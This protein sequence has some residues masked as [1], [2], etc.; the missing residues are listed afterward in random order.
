[1]V[2]G[3][4]RGGHARGVIRGAPTCYR[5]GMAKVIPSRDEG[6]LLVAAIRVQAHLDGRPP[7]INDVADLLGMPRELMQVLALGLESRG[8]V[9]QLT[10]AFE[11]R[12]D[13]VDAAAVDELPLAG[14]GP[15]LSTELDDFR[16]AFQA[17]QDDLRKTF[18]AEALQ[19]KTDDRMDHLAEQLR[20]F[21]D[22]GSAGPMFSSLSG[23]PPDDDDDD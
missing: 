2:A 10:N 22:K 1:M 9:R 8:I 18:G 7:L 17:K 13:I 3:R 19:K 12:L 21:K 16:K 5:S 14:A 15:R 20:K 6:H 23:S 11:T 4:G